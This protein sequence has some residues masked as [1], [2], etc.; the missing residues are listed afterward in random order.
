[1]ATQDRRQR[2]SDPVRI[3]AFAGSTRR[4]SF[5]DRLVRI[6]E[7]GATDAGSAVTH[8]DLR[9]YR[10]PLF[11]TDAESADGKPDNAKALKQ[12]MINHEGFLI[13]APEYNSSITGVLK[14]HHRL[15]CPRPDGRQRVAVG[16]LS[17]EGCHTHERIARC[18]GWA[19]GA[20]APAVDSRQPRLHRVA[21]TGGHS[22]SS[23]GVRGGRST[24]RPTAT[25]SDRRPG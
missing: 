22:E 21:R 9:D 18:A 17:R 15:G 23:R 8:I 1:M 12:C 24:D 5:N 20:R 16:S 4:E 6:A 13:S 14:K 11:D 25:R 19:S 10:L 3:L 7:T 2:M